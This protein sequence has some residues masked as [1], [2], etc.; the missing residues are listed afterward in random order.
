[1]HKEYKQIIDGANTAVLF[2]HGILG[3]PNH[4]K[5]FIPLVPKEYSVHNLLLDGHG[6]GVKEFSRASMNSWKNQVNDATEQLLKTHKQIIIMAHSMGTLFALQ[7]AV[8]RATAIKGLFLLATPLKVGL[9]FKMFSNSAKLY[10]NK[11]KPDDIEA[12][13]YKAACGINQDKRFWLYLGWVPRFFE[14]FKE[15]KNTRPILKDV[16]VPCFVFQSKNDEMVSQKS[17]EYI[18]TNPNIKLDIL[19]NSSHHYYFKDDYEKLL[20]EFNDFI[21]IK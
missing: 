17:I 18:K 20:L 6:S 3:T 2:V 13:A 16:L 19:Q 14:L 15:I 10:F 4:F 11:I 9:K 7:Q 12:L 21:Q 1:M 5:D 8:K